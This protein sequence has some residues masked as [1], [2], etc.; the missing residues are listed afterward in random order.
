[1]GVIVDDPNAGTI[2]LNNVNAPRI[3]PRSIYD[4]CFIITKPL[5]FGGVIV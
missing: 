3:A 2:I 1:M 4:I 5:L